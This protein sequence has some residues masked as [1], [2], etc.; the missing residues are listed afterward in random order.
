VV[1][2]LPAGVGLLVGGTCRRVLG[3]S[4]TVVQRIR[5]VGT[6]AAL[7]ALAGALA[8]TLAGG[9]LAAG[10]FDPVVVPPW[11]VLLAVLLW[12]GGPGA[13][14]ALVQRGAEAPDGYRHVEEERRDPE[15]GDWDDEW[16]EAAYDE[17]GHDVPGHDDLEPDGDDPEDRGPVDAVGEAETDDDRQRR[18]GASAEPVDHGDLDGYARPEDEVRDGPVDDGPVDDGPVDDGPADDDLADREPVDGGLADDSAGDDPADDPAGDDPAAAPAPGDEPLSRARSVGAR[19]SEREQRRREKRRE[20]TRQEREGGPRAS[21]FRR[22]EPRQGPARAA[23]PVSERR[24]AEPPV[25]RRAAGP[26]IPGSRAPDSHT[27][28]P[29]AS[30]EPAH[31]APREGTEAKP[32]TVAELVALRARQAEEAARGD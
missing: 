29:R 18:R 5:A 31:D 8:A 11:L 14:V 22:A 20:R 32:R 26:R 28:G 9:R 25:E 10:P 17:S 30:G 23:E 13:L 2:L 27:P 12:V 16:D 6:A 21:R 7:L 3:P 4:S 19:Y 15:T 24:A 1:F